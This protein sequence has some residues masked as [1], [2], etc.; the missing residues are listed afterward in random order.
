ME[1]ILMFAF[2]NLIS[3]NPDDLKAYLLE[4]ASK[5]EIEETQSE[6]HIHMLRLDGN[7]RPRINDLAVFFGL[8]YY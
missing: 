1:N 5:Q 3:G 7:N 2:E 6:L 8:L 4:V